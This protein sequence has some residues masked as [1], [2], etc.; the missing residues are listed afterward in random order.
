[1][2]PD[3]GLE[4][5]LR[6]CVDGLRPASVHSPDA[7]SEIPPEDVEVYPMG[8]LASHKSLDGQAPHPPPEGDL[9]ALRFSTVSACVSTT[10]TVSSPELVT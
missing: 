2:W 10:E 3:T 5:L 8:I 6:P 7:S 1:M 9:G 4:G